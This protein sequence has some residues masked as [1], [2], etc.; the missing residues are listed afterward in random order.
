MLN[1]E[2]SHLALYD[3]LTNTRNYR[4]YKEHIKKEWGRWKRGDGELAVLM[5]D[6]DYFKKYNDTYGHLKGDECLVAVATALKEVI[7]RP[8]DYL[9]RYGGE[10]FVFI[11]PDTDLEGALRIA[12]NARTAVR[13]LGIEHKSSEN[14]DVVTVSI[15]IATTSQLD[16][17]DSYKSLMSVADEA[18]YVAKNSGRDKVM[19]K[20]MAATAMAR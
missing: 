6:L 13:Q 11:L 4:D 5:C 3:G 19:V 15:G 10:E 9:A 16:T 14:F 12:E 8:N 7:K 18:L 2:L 20:D 17:V 1:T